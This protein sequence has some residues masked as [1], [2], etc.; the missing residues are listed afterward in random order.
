VKPALLTSAQ[1]AVLFRALARLLSSGIAADRAVAAMADLLGAGH[2][3]RFR[4]ASASMAGGASL[5]EAGSRFGLLNAR[6]RELIHLAE[7]SGTLHRAA[8]LL[9]DAYGHRARVFAALRRRMMLPLFVLVLASILLPLPALLAGR[10]GAGEFLWRALSPVAALLLVA[11]LVKGLI[12]RTAARG[13]SPASRWLL[14]VPALSR[15]LAQVNRLELMEGLTLLLG[16]GVP[17]KAAVEG[18]IDALTNP[19]ARSLYAP[20]LL[21]LEEAG[22]SGALRSVGVL[23]SDEFAVASASEQAGRL[24]EG[25]QRVAGKLRGGLEY[26]LDLASEWLPRGIYLVILALAA[27]GLMA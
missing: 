13:D 11:G 17:V 2:Q 23:E 6:D 24:A 19:A 4:G 26:R 8:A 7:V 14:R 22:L 9:A 20:A 3:H 18:A 10:T 27:A 15:A 5:A 21:R 16:A 12:R 1:R 25:L